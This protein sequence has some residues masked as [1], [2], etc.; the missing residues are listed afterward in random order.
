MDLLMHNGECHGV[1]A[2]SLEDGLL[3]RFLT[4]HTVLALGLVTCLLAQF[5]KTVHVLDRT[6]R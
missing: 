6:C 4:N 2:L 3:H 5:I 1:I